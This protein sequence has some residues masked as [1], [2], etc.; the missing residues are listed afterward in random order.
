M[1]PVGLMTR[2]T[3]WLAA[4]P[5]EREAS[6]MPAAHA[7]RITIPPWPSYAA[8]L[9]EGAARN[10]PAFVRALRLIS[11]SIANL[12]LVMYRQDVPAPEQPRLLRQP[13]PIRHGGIP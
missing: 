7:P 2:M 13:D 4:E 5:Y 12:P 3:D 9:D 8:V 6:T 11:G 1:W 10:I